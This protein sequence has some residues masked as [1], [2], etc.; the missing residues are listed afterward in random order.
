QR[1]FESTDELAPLRTKYRLKARPGGE[2]RL[3]QMAGLVPSHFNR[4]PHREATRLLNTGAVRGFDILRQENQDAWAEIWKGR[5]RLLGAESRWQKIADAAFYYLHASAHASSLSSTSMFG[6]AYWPNYHYYRG[7]VM[8]DIE[9]FVFPA[10]LLTDPHAADALLSYR[11]D[12]LEGA[13][14]NAALNGYRGLQFPW[15]SGPR[16]GNEMIRVS[17]PLVT[18]EQHISLSVALAFARYA[19]ATGDQDFLRERAGPAL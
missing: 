10:L 19:H 2:Y 5:V 6:L 14:R 4:E 9:T 17:A 13:R 16:D 7:Q 8:W 1:A 11:S 12:R 15:A 3:R 18:L